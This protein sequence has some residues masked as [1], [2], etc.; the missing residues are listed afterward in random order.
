MEKKDLIEQLLKAAKSGD[1]EA[2]H[3]DADDLL[4]Q[5]INDAEIK[6]AYEAVPK[7]YA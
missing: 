3:G 4:I 6:D 7:W 1:T 5:Y 2:A